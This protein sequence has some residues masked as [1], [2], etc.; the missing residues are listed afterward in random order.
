MK[1]VV[2]T[3]PE[4]GIEVKDVSMPTLGENDVLVKV[5]VA[6]VCGT[7]VGMYR[8]S[9][10]FMGY[11]KIPVIL[12]HEYS[13]QL[14]E[15]GGDVKGFRVGERVVSEPIKYCS[16]CYYCK[17][18]VTNLCAS[19]QAMGVHYD[20]AFA[21]YISLPQNLI[22][23]VPAALSDQEA[24]LL[25]PTAVAFHAVT[26]RTNVSAGD[27]VVVM[28]PGPIGILAA[29]VAR[30]Q[31]AVDVIVAGLEGDRERLSIAESLEFNTSIVDREDL[32]ARI[33]SLTDGRGARV[34]IEAAG[35]PSAMSQAFQMVRKGG[36]V[37][38]IGISPKPGEVPYASIVRRELRIQGSF[39]FRWDDMEGGIHL[40][41]KG[42]VK[43]KPLITH[44]FPLERAEEGLNVAEAKKACKVLLI[45]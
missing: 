6:A 4:V 28:G 41:L 10:A 21:E 13:G 27:L 40:A 20:G 24:A 25:E 9:P 31:G 17:A 14:V 37:T 3:K 38:M 23:K 36:E 7:D 8:F 22:H 1:G 15:V 11:A 35:S 18:G 32:V 29:Q 45:P 39:G 5:N 42:A 34:V 26:K 2:K 16:E 33:K 30:S 43:L 12:G 19:F 44:S